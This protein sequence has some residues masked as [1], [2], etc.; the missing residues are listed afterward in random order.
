MTPLPSP[1]RAKAFILLGLGLAL[2]ACAHTYPKPALIY[3]P[4]GSI[5]QFKRFER[6]PERDFQHRFVRKAYSAGSESDVELAGEDMQPIVEEWGKPDFV[7]KPF[8]ALGGELVREWVYLDNRRVFQFVDG[9]LV[10]EGELTDLEQLLIRLG[11]PD[12]MT[13]TIGESGIVRQAMVYH[14][15]ILPGRL[16]TYNLANGWIVHAAEGN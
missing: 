1:R 2:A 12:A 9:H 11:Y 10:F 3:N 15:V 7:R 13:T 8:H 5:S 16:E 6:F 4:D 14:G